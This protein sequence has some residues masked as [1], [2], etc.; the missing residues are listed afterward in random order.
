MTSST[1][2]LS[3]NLKEYETYIIIFMGHNLVIIVMQNLLSIGLYGIDTNV[4][5]LLVL[6]EH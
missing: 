3:K 1:N 5:H 6:F 4:I 2:K